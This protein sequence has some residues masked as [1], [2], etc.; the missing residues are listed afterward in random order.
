MASIATAL[1]SGD[2]VVIRDLVGQVSLNG[3]QATLLHFHEDV[4]RWAVAVD[5][6]AEAVRVKPQNVV[7]LVVPEL[8]HD[9]LVHVFLHIDGANDKQQA[10]NLALVGMVSRSWRLAAADKGLEQRWRA[11]CL[12]ASPAAPATGEGFG[13]EDYVCTPFTNPTATSPLARQCPASIGSYRL[14]FSRRTRAAA[15]AAKAYRVVGTCD[16]AQDGGEMDRFCCTRLDERALRGDPPPLRY[17]DLSFTF[18]LFERDGCRRDRRY[19]NL[20]YAAD[21]GEDPKTVE[22]YL[23]PAVLSAFAGPPHFS[24]DRFE[25]LIW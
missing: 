8:A 12:R 3:Q 9:L 20:D 19:Y 24:G 15:A 14:L 7:P 4:G 10:K 16:N 22:D 17:S 1:I 11:M 18:E 21:E 13:A 5:G 6:R 2:R 23:S 25:N